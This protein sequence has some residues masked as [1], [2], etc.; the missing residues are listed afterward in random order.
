MSAVLDTFRRLNKRANDGLHLYGCSEDGTICVISFEPE[1][2]PDLGSPDKTQLVLDE[3]PYKPKQRAS[4]PMPPALPNG[5]HA[6][7]NPSSINVLKPKPKLAGPPQ[8]RR[9]VDLANGA[10]ASRSGFKAPAAMMSPISISDPFSAAPLQPLVS[11]SHANASTARMFQDVPHNLVNGESSSPRAAAKR[12]AN[13]LGDESRAPKGRMMISARDATGGDVRELRA[14]RVPIAGSGAGPSKLLPVPSVQTLLRATSRDDPGV[15]IEAS[16]A[17]TAA[18]RNRITLVVSGQDVWVDYVPSAV[19]CMTATSKFAAVALE[20][21]SLLLYS[22]AGRQ[23]VERT[24]QDIAHRTAWRPVTY[25][26][27]V[28]I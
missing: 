8:P 5:N 11:P 18:E 7:P 21:G 3:F 6:A 2:F 22:P 15:H 1:E 14:P 13:L 12:K 4:A 17:A 27:R 9:R 24:V 16:N 10:G 20:N 19:L 23:C 26:C 25:H 28:T